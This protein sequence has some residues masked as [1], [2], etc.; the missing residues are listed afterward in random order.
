[1]KNLKD[2]KKEFNSKGFVVL[3]KVFLKNQIKEL[4]KQVEKIKKKSISIKNPHLHFTKDKKLIQFI[5]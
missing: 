3:R 5:I 4:L 2:I 1:M